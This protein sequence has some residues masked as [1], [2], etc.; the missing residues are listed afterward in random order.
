[1]IEKKIDPPRHGTR[2]F[3]SI[4]ID[5]VVLHYDFITHYNNIFFII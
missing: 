5:F 2:I 1:M 4:A 3:V